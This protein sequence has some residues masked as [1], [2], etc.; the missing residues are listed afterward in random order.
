M[1]ALIYRSRA[2]AFGLFSFFGWQKDYNVSHVL[3]TK[4]LRQLWH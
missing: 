1:C 2:P 4:G 3:T